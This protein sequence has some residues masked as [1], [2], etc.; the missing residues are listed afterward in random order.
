MDTKPN[1]I[2]RKSFFSKMK[3]DIFDMNDNK[4]T[5]SKISKSIKFPEITFSRVTTIANE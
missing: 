3:S 4:A 2:S 1:Q 5:S